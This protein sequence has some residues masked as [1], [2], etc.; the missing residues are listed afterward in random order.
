MP[1]TQVS[2]PGRTNVGEAFNLSVDANNAVL[3][4]GSNQRGVV[5]AFAAMSALTN[6]TLEF[7]A[8][9]T[10]GQSAFESFF[11]FKN[12]SS[13]SF[14]GMANDNPGNTGNVNFSVQYSGDDAFAGNS[15]SVFTLGSWTHFAA[16]HNATSK[17]VSV[18]INGALMSTSFA[19]TGTGTLDGFV[20]AILYIANDGGTSF[21]N[22]SFA[23]IR[24]WN[25]VRTVAEIVANKNYYL[26][27]T[28]ESAALVANWNFNQG[29]GTSVPNT[30][31]S[32]TGDMSLTNTPTWIAGPT[33]TVKNYNGPRVAAGTRTLAGART[34][35]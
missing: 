26:D 2:M 31:S 13:V 32:G 17:T 33:L 24:L 3:F 28:Q 18:Y 22:T 10:A 29:S 27:P 19:G 1:R 7:W 35:A 6:F 12:N 25:T 4:N 15:G 30:V 23:C 5:N 14:S 34:L 20:N 9:E 11:Q 8:N 21:A 16:V